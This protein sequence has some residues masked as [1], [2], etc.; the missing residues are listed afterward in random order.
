MVHTGQRNQAPSIERDVH[1]EHRTHAV[2]DRRVD[3]G[4]WRVEV[5]S[6]FTARAREVEVRG[7]VLLV[8]LYSELNLNYIYAYQ[9][10]ALLTYD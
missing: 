2:N 8:D 3:D 10:C 9:Y 4:D 5:A 7:A 1:V 6:N